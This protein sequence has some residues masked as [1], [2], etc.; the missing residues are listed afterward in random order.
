MINFRFNI[1]FILISLFSMPLYA[2]NERKIDAFLEKLGQDLKEIDSTARLIDYRK[3][4]SNRKIY[5]EGQMGKKGKQF[6]QRIKYY[7]NGLKKEKLKIYQGSISGLVLVTYIVKIN[8]KIHFIK[9]YETERDKYSIIRKT[10]K[11]VLIDNKLYQKTFFD[12]YGN[13]IK[14][15]NAILIPLTK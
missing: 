9:H 1:I 4:I 2:Q 6:I 3:S 11:E 14:K 10:S 12:A 5:I 8:D 7:R 13:E 15:E